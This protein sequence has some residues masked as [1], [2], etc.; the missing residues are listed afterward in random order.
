M[1]LLATGVDSPD[2]I[3]REKSPSQYA[4]KHP[5]GEQQQDRPEYQLGLMDR[6]DCCGNSEFRHLDSSWS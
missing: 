5:S 1:R 4:E 6:Y 2:A 3:L